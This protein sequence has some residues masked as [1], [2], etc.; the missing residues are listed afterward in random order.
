[1]IASRMY[2]CSDFLQRVNSDRCHICL[3]PK[4]AHP[5]ENDSRYWAEWLLAELE[6][7]DWDETT[8]RELV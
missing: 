7:A 2:V 1:M 5:S 6:I 8:L 4:S 3:Q